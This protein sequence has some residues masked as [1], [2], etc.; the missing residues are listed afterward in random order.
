MVQQIILPQV[1]L[2]SGYIATQIAKNGFS[3]ALRPLRRGHGGAGDGGVRVEG[4]EGEVAH[5]CASR[6]NSPHKRWR[7]G[8]FQSDWYRVS[9]R[10]NLTSGTPT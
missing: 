5:L 10:T 6:F 8:T 7:V 9:W 3:P 4:R 2:K 1:A